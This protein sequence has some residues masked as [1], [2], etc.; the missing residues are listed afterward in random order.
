VT[1]TPGLFGGLYAW[2]MGLAA[3][4]RATWWLAGLSFAES[5][6]FPIP[7]DVMLMPMALARPQRAWFLAA[8][9]TLASVVGGV[10]GYCIG[11]LA[12]EWIVPLIERAG[13]GEAYTMARAWFD[14]W[15]MLAVL[16]AGFS[17]IP[18]KIFTI[19]A[20]ALSM[21][22]PAFLL[23]SALGRGARFFL[24]AGLLKAGGPKMEA[25]VRRHVETLGWIVVVALGGI[26]AVVTLAHRG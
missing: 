12:I 3:Q 22:L 9:T 25:A 7:P 16:A 20:G 11:L 13:Y 23:M 26:V 1:A 15:G 5:S 8:V 4:R 18:Y 6:F 21:F 17:P 2:V 24:V 10:A 14:R 19:A